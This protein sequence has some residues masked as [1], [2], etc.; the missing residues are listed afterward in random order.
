MPEINSILYYTVVWLVPHGERMSQ[1]G[2]EEEPL[3]PHTILPP[4]IF[5]L[6]YLFINHNI[7]HPYP[8]SCTQLFIFLSTPPPL[9]L[10]L[11]LEVYVKIARR[12]EHGSAVQSMHGSYRGLA[13]GF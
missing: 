10:T 3:R 5:L 1:H 8:H 7:R 6:L 12:L 9:L 4:N 13:Y 11:M 2:L